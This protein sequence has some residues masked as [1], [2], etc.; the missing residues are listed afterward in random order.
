MRASNEQ[1]KEIKLDSNDFFKWLAAQPDERPVNMESN[2]WNKNG[3]DCSCVM[4]Q[5]ALDTLPPAI[6]MDAGYDNINAYTN[7]ETI[8]YNFERILWEFRLKPMKTM[9][10]LKKHFAKEIAALS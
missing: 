5:F 6:T 4:I 10:E 9:G 3:G 2:K 1:M 8:Y 7:K